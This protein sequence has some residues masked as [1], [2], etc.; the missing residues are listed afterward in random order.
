[1]L[2]WLNPGEPMLSLLLIPVTFAADPI[3]LEVIARAQKNLG[4][5]SLTLVVNQDADKLD[6]R[7]DCAGAWGESHGGASAGDKI[8]M[9]LDVPVGTHS[10]T[11]SLAAEFS[12]GS[13]GEMPL[14]FQVTMLGPMEILVPADKINME[15]RTLVVMMDRQPSQVQVQAYGPG[16]LLIGE[17]SVPSIGAGPGD[18]IEVQWKSEGEVI[19]LHVVGTDVDG[20]WTAKDLMPWYYNIPHE[21][22][23]FESGKSQILPQEEPKLAAAL[24]EANEVLVKYGTV[25]KVNLYVAGYTDTVGDK[26]NNKRLSQARAAAIARWYRDHGF[27]GEIYYQGFGEQ[28]LAVATPDNTAQA[29]NRRALYVLAAETPP[30]SASMPKDI[31]TKL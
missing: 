2:P 1:M 28:G 31:W 26:N 22:V 15:E 18:P 13:T 7:V 17:V 29:Q 5:P 16:D 24:V 25:A 20:F 21:D 10:C 8:T 12:D 4:K 14:T 9:E 30:V 3:A 6:V 23:V 27:T 19:R 11:G